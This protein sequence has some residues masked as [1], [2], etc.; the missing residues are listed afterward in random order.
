MAVVLAIV[1]VLIWKIRTA[2]RRG[3]AAVNFTSSPG[4]NWIS[5]RSAT[6]CR[7][8]F[9]A[10]VGFYVVCALLLAGLIAPILTA[11]VQAQALQS[12]SKHMRAGVRFQR[13]CIPHAACQTNTRTRQA[14]TIRPSSYRLRAR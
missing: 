1:I 4:E 6:S 5:A 2:F 13:S 11:H 10:I 9:W 8:L 3:I 7:S 14:H 12:G